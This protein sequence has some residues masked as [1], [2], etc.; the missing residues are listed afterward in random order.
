MPGLAQDRIQAVHPPDREHIGHAAAADEDRV[1]RQ[2]QVG[3][4]G[5]VRHREQVEV[6][7]AGG[8]TEEPV[9]HGHGP[10]GVVAGGRV[11]HADPGFPLAGEAQCIGQM[12]WHGPFGHHHA[13]ADRDDVLALV[14][15]H[16][17]TVALVTGSCKPVVGLCGFVA[18][19]ASKGHS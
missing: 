19:P 10:A 9:I 4:V 18:L 6:A 3:R 12:Q 16:T 8:R 1:L 5:D 13:T 11:D 7:E 2:Q 15:C 17:V 14:H